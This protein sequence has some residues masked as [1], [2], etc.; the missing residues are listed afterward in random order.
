MLFTLALVGCATVGTLQRAQTAGEDQLQVAIEPGLY[1]AQQDG[2]VGLL[3]YGNVAARYGVTDALDV[4]ARVGFSGAELQAKWRVTPSDSPVIVAVAPNAGGLFL[5]E[6]NLVT[7]QVPVIVE[8]PVGQH[9]LVLGPKAWMVS[10]GAGDARASMLALGG[11]VGVALRLGPSFV[12]V[13]E[14]AAVRPVYGAYADV[15]GESGGDTVETSFAVT[16]LSLSMLFGG[17]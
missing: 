13:P 1:G 4:G 5:G 11:S 10:T 9:A 14:Y 16:H 15:F 8:V 2:E 6:A 3:P 12:V 7:A 17:R